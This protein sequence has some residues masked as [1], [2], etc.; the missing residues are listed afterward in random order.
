M[1]HAAEADIV[2]PA[3]AAEDPDGLRRGNPSGK[4]FS[5]QLAGVAIAAG[6]DGS[7][8][9]CDISL[10]SGLVRVAVFHGVEPL[11]RGSLQIG[12]GI[13]DSDELLGEVS[14]MRADCLLCDVHAVAVLG[15]VFEQELHHAGP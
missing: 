2:C 5:A 11:L 6:N 1:V 13:V 12:V 9:L 7:F 8:E 3:V 14:Q 15:V 10:G 4:D